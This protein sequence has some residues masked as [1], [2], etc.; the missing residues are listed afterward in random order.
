M[1]YEF[2]GTELDGVAAQLLKALRYKLSELSSL[3]EK[4]RWQAI[5]DYWLSC[6]AVAPRKLNSICVSGYRS[7]T[8]PIWSGPFEAWLFR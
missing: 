2:G 7:R 1:G 3:V 4:S 5:I 6:R 8:A